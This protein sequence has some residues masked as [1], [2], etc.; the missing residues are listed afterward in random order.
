MITVSELLKRARKEK[1]ISLEHLSEKTK[2]RKKYLLALEKGEWEKL[3]GLAYIK[4]FLKSYAE[5]VALDPKQILAF[6][7]RE[8]KQETKPKLI[9]SGLWQPLEGSSN[10]LLTIKKKAFK[11]FLRLISSRGLVARR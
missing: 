1:G 9:P 2:I 3:P 8:Y 4:G 7:R 10:L 6:F 11:I 5:A